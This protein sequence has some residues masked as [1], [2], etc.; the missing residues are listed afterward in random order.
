MSKKNREALAE[1]RA[2]LGTGYTPVD[3]GPWR[4]A[5][6]AAI[7]A[8]R[9]GRPFSMMPAKSSGPLSPAAVRMLARYAAIREALIKEGAKCW[10]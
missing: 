10:E 3:L 7:E 6:A 4:D 1:I 2:K 5:V 8:R 9:D